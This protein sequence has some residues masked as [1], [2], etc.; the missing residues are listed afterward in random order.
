MRLVTLLLLGSCT[1]GC[2]SEKEAK[3]DAPFASLPG[4]QASVNQSSAARKI[5]DEAIAAHGE[6][7]SGKNQ[8]GRVKVFTVGYPQPEYRDEI[9]STLV[10]CYPDQLRE[11]VE[12]TSIAGATKQRSDTWIYVRDHKQ[13]WQAKG[14]GVFNSDSDLRPVDDQFP[15]HLVRDL[16][17]MRDGLFAIEVVG[18]DPLTP[19]LRATGLTKEAASFF[20]MTFD[21]T[22]KLVRRIMSVVSNPMTGR[23]GRSET[24]FS[25]YANFSGAMLPT[26]MTGLLDGE[27]FVEKT[28]QEFVTLDRIDPAEFKPQMK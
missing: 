4:N 23:P 10:F 8:T 12:F 9:R 11:V 19:T 5:V 2:N 15:F 3:N 21:P 20:E 27:R 25:N 18:N 13:A 24:T 22:T 7:F 26:K 16:K 28:V 1:M 17:A 14:D 6:S